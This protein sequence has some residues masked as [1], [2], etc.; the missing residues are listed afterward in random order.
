MKEFRDK[1]FAF[2]EAL[3]MP[4]NYSEA[5]CIE[6]KDMDQVVTWSNIGIKN[7]PDA[8]FRTIHRFP[9]EVREKV[10]FHIL[11]DVNRVGTIKGSEGT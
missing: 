7:T 4:E 10:V 5:S 3:R 8:V 1:Y 9:G 6:T 11:I 2:L